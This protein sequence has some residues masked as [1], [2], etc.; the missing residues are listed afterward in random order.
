MDGTSPTK[1]LN[2]LLQASS[3]MSRPQMAA[4]IT[5]GS[6]ALYGFTKGSKSGLALAAIGGALI[7]AGV[8]SNRQPADSYTESSVVVNC[9]PEEAYKFW[10]DFENLPRFMQHLE[11]VTITDNNRSKWTVLG[12]AGSRIK[13][14]A[15]IVRE[16]E[17]EFISWRSLQDS[18]ISVEGA[19]EFRRA[20]GN[21]GTL[22][23]VAILY[24][25]PGGQFGASIAKLLGADPKFMVRHDL[26]RLK[27]LLETG[28]IPTIEGQTHGPRSLK[29][30]AARMID[31]DRP[32][33]REANMAEV[34]NA[35]RRIA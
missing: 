13:W 1:A 3:S 17:N 9:T 22:I 24:T 27:A 32:V 21:R 26:R 2:D 4:L 23:S 28:E 8:K 6:L 29:A 12:P 35:K 31:P 18:D 16:Q 5:G 33:R 14:D 15:E 25:P 11:S 34:I 30:A 20:T 19:V 7:Y 10:R